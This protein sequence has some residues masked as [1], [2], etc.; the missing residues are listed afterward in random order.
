LTPRDQKRVCLAV[1]I[2][3]YLRIVTR[4]AFPLLITLLGIVLAIWTP[5]VVSILVLLLAGLSLVLAYNADR[6][7]RLVLFVLS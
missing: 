4:P 2:I 6:L 7:S 5:G 3:F 1:R